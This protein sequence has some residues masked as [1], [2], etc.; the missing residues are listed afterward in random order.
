MRAS[1]CCA[2]PTTSRRPSPSASSTRCW[3]SSRPS[4]PDPLVTNDVALAASRL[5][6]GGLV[7]IPTETVYG[8]A[9]DASSPAPVARIFSVKGRPPDHPLILHVLPA[10]LADWAASVPPAAAVLAEAGWPG[11]LTLPLARP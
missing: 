11:P 3:S 5:R 4:L 7:A 9:A 2:T 6:A 1:S 8:L 10:W